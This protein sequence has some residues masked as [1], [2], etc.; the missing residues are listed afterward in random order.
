MRKI[1]VLFFFVVYTIAYIHFAIEA[2]GAGHGTLIFFAPLVTWPLLA[3]AGGILAFLKRPI[4]TVTFLCPIL[5]HY[6]VTFTLVYGY[7]S[8]GPEAFLLMW[9][10]SHDLILATIFWYFLG[11]IALW[12]GFVALTRS[13]QESNI[14]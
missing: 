12:W 10:Y 1:F 5:V 4:R 8:D 7:I 2:G 6:I 11:Q 3:I 14:Q 13:Y 9:N